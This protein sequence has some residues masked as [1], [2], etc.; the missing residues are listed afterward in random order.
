M[1]PTLV[2]DVGAVIENYQLCQSRTVHQCAAVLKAS[3]Y[4]LG[5]SRLAEALAANGCQKIFLATLDEATELKPGFDGDLFVLN[6]EVDPAILQAISELKCVPVIYSKQ[7]LDVWSQISDGP[8]MLMANTGMN[9]MG[10]TLTEV[11]QIRKSNHNIAWLAT[12]LACES[13]PEDPA[14]E[15]QVARFREFQSLL[16]SVPTSFGASGAVLS[17]KE[18]Q[19]ELTR[20]G[21]ALYGGN[22]F[23]HQPN[24]TRSVATLRMPL[25]SVYQGRQG[26]TVGYGGSY[27]LPETMPLGTVGIGYADGIP[28]CSA[29]ELV[30]GYHGIPLPTVGRISMD[31]ITLD[32]RQAPDLLA[33]STVELFGSH[34]TIDD[35]AKQ[36][37]TIPYEVIARLGPRIRREYTSTTG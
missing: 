4:G 26:E 3:A 20:V 6:T 8:C 5:A 17:R 36:M 24:P 15:A 1:Q 22:P 33:G 19:G 25:L 21:I 31:L 27:R 32:L 29:G 2:T 12:H 23:D 9:R 30:F 16:P 7:Q 35:V 28:R 37:S 34:Q 13:T 10:C 14:N 18:L 11:D